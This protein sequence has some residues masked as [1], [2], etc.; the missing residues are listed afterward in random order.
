MTEDQAK[1]GLAGLDNSEMIFYDNRDPEGSDRLA[2]ERILEEEYN[3]SRI[4][5]I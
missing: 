3:P 4:K 5:G 1:N 2:I